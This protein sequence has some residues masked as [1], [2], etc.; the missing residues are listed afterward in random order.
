MQAIMGVGEAATAKR[1]AVQANGLTA[2]LQAV[3]GGILRYGTVVLLVYFGAFKFTATEA[4]AIQPLIAHSP[5]LGWLY[6][7]LSVQAV[8]NI[9]GTGAGREQVRCG[10][11]PA[12]G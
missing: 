11:A 5:F 10:R 12:R 4:S 8:S 3:G 6:G 7:V 2:R 1:S 9:I